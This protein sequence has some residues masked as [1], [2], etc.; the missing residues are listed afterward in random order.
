MEIRSNTVLIKMEELVQK[1]RAAENKEKLNGY[2]IAVQALCDILLDKQEEL[3]DL[4]EQKLVLAAP[5]PVIQKEI[6]NPVSSLPQG[7][8]AKINEANG[9]SI[10]DF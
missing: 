10:F 4:Y 8:P 5:S 7:K 6:V 1:A 2:I 9:E 3:S